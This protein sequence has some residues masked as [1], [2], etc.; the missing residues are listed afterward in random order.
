MLKTEVKQA[1]TAVR[2]SLTGARFPEGVCRLTRIQVVF[3]DFG[4]PFVSAVGFM[5]YQ[6][7]RPF[8]SPGATLQEL[9]LHPGLTK[10][11]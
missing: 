7:E 9:S 11:L 6:G 2:V 3:P 10:I 4:F 1:L 5:R 8:V